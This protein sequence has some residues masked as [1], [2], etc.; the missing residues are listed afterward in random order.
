MIPVTECDNVLFPRDDEVIASAEGPDF[1][2]ALGHYRS[3]YQA[4]PVDEILTLHPD[5]GYIWR[6]EFEDQP[7]LEG[8]IVLTVV[9]MGHDR[10]F[11][12]TTLCSW[13]L[14]P[15]DPRIASYRASLAH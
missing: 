11:R 7:A 15:T 6:A 5:Y 13:V 9:V 3:L 4:P 1:D 10:P 8:Y 2:D 14:L 12:N